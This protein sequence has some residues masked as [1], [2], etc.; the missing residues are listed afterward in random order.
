MITRAFRICTAWQSF[1]AECSTLHDIFTKLQYP[2][3]MISN[4][5]RNLLDAFIQQPEVP[6]HDCNPTPMRLTVPFKSEKVSKHLRS[7]L[8]VLSNKIDCNIVPVFTSSKLQQC[9]SSPEV[10]DPLVSRACVVY[11][12]KCTCDMCYVG[13][14]SNHTRFLKSPSCCT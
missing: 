10:K 9:I 11:Q 4:T 6:P 2:S 5:I 3:N 14:T 13:F 1:N 7:S 12:Y 8:K